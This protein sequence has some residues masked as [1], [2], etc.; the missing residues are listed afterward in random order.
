M[1]ELLTF[2]KFNDISLANKIADKLEQAGISC[3]IQDQSKF[4]DVSFAY[5]KVEPHI[6]LKLHS[7]DFEKA[8]HI[9][10]DYY[11]LQAVTIEKDYYRFYFTDAELMEIIEKPDEWGRFDYQLAKKILAERGR[12]IQPGM[13]EMLKEKRIHELAVP[14]R[15]SPRFLVFGYMSS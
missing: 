10:D 6:L 14:E 9:L 7:E 12:A 13:E 2:Q 5:N 1:P 4:F 8:S 15:V 3:V 11:S